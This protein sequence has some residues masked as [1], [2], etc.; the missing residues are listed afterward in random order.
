MKPSKF[1]LLFF[2]FL[3]VILACQSTSVTPSSAPNAATS[4]PEVEPVELEDTLPVTGIVIAERNI[5]SLVPLGFLEQDNSV[6][7]IAWTSQNSSPG[8]QWLAVSTND[9]FLYDPLELA[10]PIHVS[11]YAPNTIAFSW[12]GEMLLYADKYDVYVWGM[13]AQKSLGARGETSDLHGNFR[14]MTMLAD[15]NSIVAIHTGISMWYLDGG[16]YEDERIKPVWVDGSSANVVASSSD[17]HLAVGARD[18][19]TVTV[20]QLDGDS[21][22]LLYDFTRLGEF[23]TELAFSA[24]GHFLATVSESEEI[25]L[26]D[27]ETGEHLRFSAKENIADIAFSPDGKILATS[28]ISGMIELWDVSEGKLLHEIVDKRN[29]QHILFSPDGTLLVSAGGEKR[30]TFWGIS[31]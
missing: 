10:N 1:A 21:L 19:G 2:L 30:L 13:A 18:H 17:G 28:A 26:W 3:G 20:W 9:V 29:G 8:Q 4:T 5:D 7:D 6:R 23:I 31:E 12:D 27:M 11:K 14:G 16:R 25:L 22:R 15:N 24:D